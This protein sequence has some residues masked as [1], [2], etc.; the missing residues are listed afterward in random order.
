MRGPDKVRSLGQRPMYAAD[1]IV[2]LGYRQVAQR[3]NLAPRLALGIALTGCEGGTVVACPPVASEASCGAI[4][5]RDHGRFIEWAQRRASRDLE[6]FVDWA[7]SS[8][9]PSPAEQVNERLNIWGYDRGEECLAGRPI[10]STGICTGVHRG[11]GWLAVMDWKYDEPTVSAVEYRGY[12]KLPLRCSDVASG[13]VVSWSDAE[14]GWVGSVCSS[15]SHRVLIDQ[16]QLTASF[17]YANTL[18]R[19]W[20]DRFV[21]FDPGAA[22]VLAKILERSKR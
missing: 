17:G 13:E 3:V 16:H 21:E 18:V 4:V 14:T 15:D 2:I 7:R 19:F 10:P 8:G 11:A 20:T 9:L 22:K 12:M 5:E 1:R 6:S